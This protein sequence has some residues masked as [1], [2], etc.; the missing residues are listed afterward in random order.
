[1]YLTSENTNPTKHDNIMSITNNL[2]IAQD[3][4]LFLIVGNYKN[5][6]IEIW[7]SKIK[8]PIARFMGK[9]SVNGVTI[10]SVDNCISH[11]D[12]IEV[13]IHVLTQ[14]SH[15]APKILEELNDP[16]VQQFNP[17]RLTANEFGQLTFEHLDEIRH[18]LLRKPFF[19]TSHFFVNKQ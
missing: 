7:P 6:K 14:A 17:D 3:R 11:R 13:L 1:V 16:L 9:I 2:S 8:N 5:L 10:F 4:E 18:G 12:T 19:S 15:M